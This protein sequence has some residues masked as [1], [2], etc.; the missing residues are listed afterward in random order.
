MLSDMHKA[1]ID[2][3][4]EIFVINKCGY[5]GENTEQEIKYAISKGK[6]VRYLEPTDSVKIL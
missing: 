3:C 5:I 6:R 1:R 2:M 4:D